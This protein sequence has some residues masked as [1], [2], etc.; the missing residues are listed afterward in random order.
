MPRSAS[1]VTL[2]GSHAPTPSS[3]SRRKWF[4]VPPSGIGAPLATRPGRSSVNQVWY[5][6]GEPPRDQ[7]LVGVVVGE[8]GLEAADLGTRPAEG[9]G[10]P[11]QLQRLRAVLGV[12][13]RD[14]LARRH[15][16]KP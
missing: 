13:D 7:V 6:S 8:P 12:V 10:G 4:E 5:S 3:R 14:E 2:Y 16:G 11:A 1:S 15:R 9:D